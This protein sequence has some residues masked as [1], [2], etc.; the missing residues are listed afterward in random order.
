MLISTSSILSENNVY[1]DYNVP[2]ST[3]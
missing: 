3:V 1:I 2:A